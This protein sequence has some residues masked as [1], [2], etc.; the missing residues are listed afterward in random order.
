MGGARHINKGVAN[1]EI[2]RKPPR[3]RTH[4]LRT[5]FFQG[6]LLGIFGLAER[7]VERRSRIYIGAETRTQGANTSETWGMNVHG[8][9]RD[10]AAGGLQLGPELTPKGKNPTGTKRFSLS[11]STGD[12]CHY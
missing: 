3:S 10:K 1:L 2:S 9:G 7:E 11:F 8:M 5:G 12:E 6:P 4:I